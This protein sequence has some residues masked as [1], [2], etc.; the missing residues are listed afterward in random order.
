MNKVVTRKG[1]TELG[2]Q[3]ALE[4]YLN[5]WKRVILPTNFMFAHEAADLERH[6]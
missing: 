2:H 6:L 4:M 5:S 1:V 3:E